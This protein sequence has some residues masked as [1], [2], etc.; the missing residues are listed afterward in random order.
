LLCI[1]IY[2]FGLYP[3]DYVDPSD[4]PDTVGVGAG[5][6]IYEKLL[7]RILPIIVPE[8][9]RNPISIVYAQNI[10]DDPDSSGSCRRCRII[11]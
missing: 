1:W 2:L 7:G 10:V 5:A 8:Y 4:I 9:R 11:S 6:G 3:Q